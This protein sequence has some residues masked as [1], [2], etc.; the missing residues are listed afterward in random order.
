LFF[1]WVTLAI[2][3]WLVLLR[4]WVLWDRD[5][6]FILCTLLTFL[7]SNIA[8]LILSG[9][10]LSLV[11]PSM[12]FIPFLRTCGID[13]PS[14][15]RALWLPMLAFQTIMIFAMG[16]KVMGNPQTFQTLLRDG[17]I[18]FFFLWGINLLN[19][20]IIFSVEPTLM[21]V[22]IFFMW[23]FTTT[24]TCRMILSLRRDAREGHADYY[25]GYQTDSTAHVEFH[26]Q[27]FSTA[28]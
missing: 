21:F 7:A 3:D 18:Y 8:V 1:G 5:R 13:N 4:L 6:T 2:N 28:S 11:I 24:A 16:W 26:H 19:T 12:H 25:D 20:A 27:S 10:G 17:Y 23:C 9:I 15:I 22:T 14:P